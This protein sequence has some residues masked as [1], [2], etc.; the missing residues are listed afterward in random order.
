[1]ANLQKEACEVL[2]FDNQ[3][4]LLLRRWSG[5]D[6]VITVLNFNTAPVVLSLPMA[7]GRWRKMLDSSEPRWQGF[8]SSLP[9]E[10]AC[11]ATVE[12][13]LAPTSA[14][15]FMRVKQTDRTSGV[16]PSG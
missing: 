10:F 16:K 9:G 7:A 11:G 8:G 15:L 5:E 1:L 6:A 2:G 4:V 13:C 14:A 3:R 12:V